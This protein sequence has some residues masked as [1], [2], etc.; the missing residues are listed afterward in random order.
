MDEPA[1][2]KIYSELTGVPD[3]AA[4][5]VFMHLDLRSEET[6]EASGTTPQDPTKAGDATKIS[7]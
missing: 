3:S 1:L 5:S 2:V 7:E 6:N 4:R